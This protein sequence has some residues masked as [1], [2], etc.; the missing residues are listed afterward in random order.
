MT[1]G[2]QT[3]LRPATSTEATEGFAADVAGGLVA[4]PKRLPA[5][6]F[7]DSAGSALFEQI[8]RLPEYYP[9]RCELAL[10]HQ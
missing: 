4:K 3:A 5:K 7:Y 6:Y 8:T 1:R 2:L 10:L 9:T